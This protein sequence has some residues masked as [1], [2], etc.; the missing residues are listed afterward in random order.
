M[1]GS[2]TQSGAFVKTTPVPGEQSFI[3][4]VH[5]VQL[6]WTGDSVTGAVPPTPINT[7]LQAQMMGR[8][9]AEVVT[10][11]GQPAPSQNW[12]VLVYDAQNVDILG[13]AGLSRDRFCP[14]VAQPLGNGAPTQAAVD[15]QLTV[16]VSGNVVPG[17]TGIIKLFTLTDRSKE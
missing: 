2:V 1:P 5:V 14:Q 15:S 3:A 16:T 11:P 8:W 10:V 9:V 13:G 12:G 6:A 17:A 4:N 7:D